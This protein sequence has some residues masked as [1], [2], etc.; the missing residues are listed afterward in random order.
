MCGRYVI[1]SKAEKIEKKFN[2][3]F[4]QP[5]T[6]NYNVSTGQI[7]PVITSD[8]PRRVENLHFGFTPSWAKQKT[9]IINA[10]A[11]GDHNKENNPKFTGAKGI[12][13]KPFFRKSIRSKRCLVLA[14]AFIE[15]TTIEKLDNPFL[16]YLRN[17]DRPFAMAGIF[18]EWKDESSNEV[19]RS[20]AIITC[21]PNSLMQKIPHHRM[22][23]ILEAKDYNK[24]LSLNT[25]LSKITS[26]LYPY[27]YKLM[28]AFPISKE[29]KKPSNNES[30][31]INPI[32]ERLIKEYDY[33]LSTVNQSY[34]EKMAERRKSLHGK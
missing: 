5:L 12:I 34:E 19:Y 14:D 4:D 27:D 6:P 3:T 25:D 13:T 8:N 24:W 16:V 31:L 11:E 10:R 22:P 29:V 26:L 15:G 2:V 30:S 20:F 9:Y 33:S 21:P 7:A 23:V 1:V 32:G 17:K 28:N 18:D